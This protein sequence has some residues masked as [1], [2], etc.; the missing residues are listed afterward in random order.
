[1]EA[2]ILVSLSWKKPFSGHVDASQ[3]LFGGMLIQ[4]DEDRRDREVALF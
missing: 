1:M 3:A 4:L 2:S